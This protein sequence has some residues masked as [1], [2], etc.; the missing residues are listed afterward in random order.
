MTNA[1]SKPSM[2]IDDI[3]NRISKYK[4][5]EL[6][7]KS[8]KLPDLKAFAKYYKLR[9]TGTKPELVERIETYFKKNKNATIIQALFRGHLVRFSIRLRGCALKERIKCVNDSDFYTLDPINEIEYNDFYSYVDKQGFIYGFSVSSLIALFKRKGHITNPYNREKLD[10]K[11]MNEIFLLYKLNNILYSDPVVENHIAKPLVNQ[12]VQVASLP[13]PGQLAQPIAPILTPSI[14]VETPTQVLNITP[15]QSELRERMNII[16]SRS[17]EDRMRELFMEMDQLGNYTN[18]TWFSSLTDRGLV[19]FFRYLYDIWTYRGQLTRQTKNRIS[20]LQDPFYGMAN[21]QTLDLDEL[22]KHCL[23][24]MEHM[25]YTGVDI[26]FQRIGTLHVLSA[27]TLVSL[28]ARQAM[29]WLY[30]GLVY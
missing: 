30:E 25:V 20:S 15:Q 28:P 4:K 22:R 14:P 17:T 3:E 18:I 19:N 7:I 26:E 5:G 1:M 27:L 13:G 21:L 2:P 11:T 10:F 12:V 24:V 8:C 6:A 23:H 29:Y 9:V 16:Q